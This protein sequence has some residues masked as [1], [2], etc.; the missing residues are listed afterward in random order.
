M[1]ISA[2]TYSQWVDMTLYASI[3]PAS[4]IY[5]LSFFISY[6]LKDI[7]LGFSLY[8]LICIADIWWCIRGSVNFVMFC[9]MAAFVSRLVLMCIV[10]YLAVNSKMSISFML[11]GYM[12]SMFYVYYK[13][14][15]FSA[16]GGVL[17]P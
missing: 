2:L 14:H 4:C 1:K 5:L 10:V 16:K 15:E 3:L 8:G 9:M 7:A 12:C 13:K 17:C 6:D 11:L